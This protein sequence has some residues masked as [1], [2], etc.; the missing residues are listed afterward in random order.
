M[1]DQYYADKEAGYYLHA[2][3]E[4]LPYLPPVSGK[5]FE[6]GCGNGE[7]LA[8][9]K[10]ENRC[11]WAGGVELF[12]AAAVKAREKA[13]LVLEG[14]IENCEIPLDE[15]SV[16]L[17]LCLDVLE[18]LV[19]PWSVLLRLN[20]FV[21]P[22]GSLICT[23]PNVRHLKVLLPLV[24]SGTWNYSDYGIL[25]RTHLRFFT[26]RTAVSLVESAGFQV[27]DVGSTGLEEGS[28]AYYLNLLSLSLLR[29]FLEYQFIIKAVKEG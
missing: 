4:I 2:R 29:P 17:M 22:G 26:R 21:K 5:V 15:G 25:D 8:L 3:R 13:D 7:T 28:K 14:N 10:H 16:D 9:L 24:V 12:P 27:V 23:L 6:V 19:D 18:H 20:R 11:N 1:S